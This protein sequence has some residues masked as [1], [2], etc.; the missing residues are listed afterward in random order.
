MGPLED[1]DDN[2]RHIALSAKADAAC[3]GITALANAVRAQ[4]PGRYH[5]SI[6]S[7]ARRYTAQVR[8]L[9]SRGSSTRNA[10]PEGVPLVCE[11]DDA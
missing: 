8:V 1:D 3:V 9:A 10:H 7:L 5:R 6:A 2:A 11:G 4:V